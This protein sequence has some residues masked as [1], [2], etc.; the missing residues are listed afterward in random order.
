MRVRLIASAAVLAAVASFIACND[1]TTAPAS[2]T[3]I[4]VMT[5]AN[6]RPTPTASTATGTA[7]YVLTGNQLTYTI[8]VNG[9]TAPASGSHIHVGAST[10]A[11]PI[12][13]PFTVSATQTGTVSSGTIDLTFPIVSGN[14][15]ITGDSLK[16]L[17]NN[18]NA[19]SNVHNSTFPAG[20]IRGQIIKQ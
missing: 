11:G 13:V 19:Y 15:S 5:G 2:T 17:L 1:S 18:G 3:F 12:V 14:S 20:E 10:V 9:L 8:T 6:E 16:V 4:A 7:T